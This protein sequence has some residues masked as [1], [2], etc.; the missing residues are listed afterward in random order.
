MDEQNN[1]NGG[2][3]LCIFTLANALVSISDVNQVIQMAA[4]L[5]AITCGGFTSFYYYKKTKSLENEKKERS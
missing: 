1:Y 4:G 3:L 5:M 2:Q